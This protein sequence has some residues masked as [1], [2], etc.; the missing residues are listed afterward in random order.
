MIFTKINT[1]KNSYRLL[2]CKD[3]IIIMAN[4][5]KNV[6]FLFIIHTFNMRSIKEYAHVTTYK[7]C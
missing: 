2:I 1:L 4:V 6:I 5:I 7:R 3:R